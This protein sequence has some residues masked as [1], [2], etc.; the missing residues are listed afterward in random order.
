V[1]NLVTSDPFVEIGESFEH[2]EQFIFVRSNV[3]QE[4]SHREPSHMRDM[5]ARLE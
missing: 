1:F 2:F 5:L 3:Q 4:S